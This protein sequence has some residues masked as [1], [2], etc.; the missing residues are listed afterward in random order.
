[1]SAY[2][3]YAPTLQMAEAENTSAFPDAPQVEA[4]VR[5]GR[6]RALA[7]AV[8]RATARLELAAAARLE[9]PVRRRLATA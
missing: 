5:P 2:L 4:A 1:M 9:R 6:T 3:S 8:L 7:A